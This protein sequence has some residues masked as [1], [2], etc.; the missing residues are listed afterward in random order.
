MSA[1]DGTQ[2]SNERIVADGLSNFTY[3]NH[4][5]WTMD[6]CNRNGVLFS[7]NYGLTYDI[8]LYDVH[9]DELLR[10]TWDDERDEF[11]PRQGTS[12]AADAPEP[13]GPIL[14]DARLSLWPS[15][16]N[17]FPTNLSYSANRPISDGKIVIYDVGGRAV[18]TIHLGELPSSGAIRLNRSDSHLPSGRYIG[19]LLGNG[20]VL[21]K[22]SFVL[23]R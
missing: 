14:A 6:H 10:V 5:A 3:Q 21:A 1:F 7:A 2:I 11:Q 15:P 19:Q 8:W 23:V 12:I 13:G 4:L 18:Q 20:R 16:S 9:E 22:R 17:T